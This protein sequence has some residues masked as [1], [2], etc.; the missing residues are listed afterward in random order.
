MKFHLSIVFLLFL[1]P[2][3]FCQSS[4][5]IFSDQFDAASSWTTYSKR[6]AAVQITDGNFIF[7]H[8]RTWSAWQSYQD[9]SYDT[10]K[11][12]SIETSVKKVSGNSLTYYGLLFGRKS[13][14][15]QFE[16]TI[17]HLGYFKIVRR[18]NNRLT[19][20]KGPTLVSTNIINKGLGANNLLSVVKIGRQ[21]DFLI[22]NQVVFSHYQRRLFGSKTG[23]V[24]YSKMS[25]SSEYL[26]INYLDDQSIEDY[27][28]EHRIKFGV[29]ITRSDQDRKIFISPVGRCSF[30]NEEITQV[31]LKSKAFKDQ[32][33]SKIKANYGTSGSYLADF[34]GWYKT[35]QDARTDRNKVLNYYM[36][37][38]KEYKIV[39]LQSYDFTPDC[40]FIENK[41]NKKSVK[42]DKQ[43][44][45]VSITGIEKGQFKDLRDGQVYPTITLRGFNNNKKMTVMTRNMNYAKYNFYLYNPSSDGKKYGRLYDYYS[46]LKACPL[47]WHVPSFTEWKMLRNLLGGKSKAGKILKSDK[48]WESRNNALLIGSNKIGFNGLGAGSIM[49]DDKGAVTNNNLNQEALFWSE[50]RI[51]SGG[52]IYVRAMRLLSDSDTFEATQVPLKEGVYY[53]CRCIKVE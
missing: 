2:C 9:T 52:T 23:F 47:G 5:I 43:N 45:D 25:I 1:T 35:T 7:T 33:T 40:N 21:L 6:D 42:K 38:F 16:F 15:T 12:W 26:T 32:W 49:K 13:N 41:E 11:D 34:A 8:K 19:T 10:E 50:G 46:A 3:V 48:G 24:V 37:N 51:I 39:N 18:L 44:L 14:E 22:N 31:D 53:S 4:N 29:A 17:N 27:I 20:I 36:F 30:K 28:N